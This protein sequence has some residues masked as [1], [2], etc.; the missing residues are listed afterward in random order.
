MLG[1]A[2]RRAF[3]ILALA[4]IST[5]IYQ[6]VLLV[7]AGH[8]TFLQAQYSESGIDG[9]GFHAYSPGLAFVPTLFVPGRWRRYDLQVSPHVQEMTVKLALRF[10]AYLRMSDLF[11]VQARLRLEGEIQRTEAFA[12]LK[13]LE[14]RPT[15]RDKFVEEQ[16]QF[17]AAE[18]FLEIA[19]D[20]RALAVVK[21]RLAQFFANTN[22]AE[23]QKRLDRQL[24]GTWFKLRF[25][26][27]RDL[28]VPDNELYAAQIRNLGE[29][30]AADRKALLTQIE[31]EADLAIDRKRNLEELNKAE[32]MG[33]LISEN[34][35]LLDYY[36]IE[37]IAPRAGQVI[38]DAST[39]D[40]SGGD[41][42]RT[43]EIL[44][45]AK[46]GRDGNNEKKGEAGGEIGRN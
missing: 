46:R 40:R 45:K 9:S 6:D 34:P 32:K 31:R 3:Q 22:L 37:K 10:S 25:I 21:T 38:L 2:F 42:G 11:Y 36:K 24:K 28:Y 41:G 23:I 27:L 17:L 29:V 35:D 39:R 7:P 43:A 14:Y 4:A 26:E 19:G 15:D 20:E 8:T 12:A 18:Y 13:A 30:A 16:L 5:V 1:D 33:A 44:N